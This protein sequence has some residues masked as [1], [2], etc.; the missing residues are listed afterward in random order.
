[1]D[2]DAAT[3]SPKQD[4]L[5]ARKCHESDAEKTTEGQPNQ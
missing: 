3:T 4:K 5:K 1:M 2:I